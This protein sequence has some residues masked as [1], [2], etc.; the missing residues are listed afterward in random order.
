MTPSD[1]ELIAMVIAGRDQRAF[2]SL[3]ARHQSAVRAVLMRLCRNA[4]LAD[5]L[6]QE[7]M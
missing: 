5:D 6:A 7:E 3:V 1:G 4:A 2:S